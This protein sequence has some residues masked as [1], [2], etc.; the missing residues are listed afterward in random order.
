MLKLLRKKTL[1]DA[2]TV[3]G[4]PLTQRSVMRHHM[5]VLSRGSGL[6]AS[7]QGSAWSPQHPLKG[8]PIG[9]A[10]EQLILHWLRAS[11]DRRTKEQTKL[12]HPHPTTPMSHWV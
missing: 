2:A 7:K 6:G 10:E 11:G 8:C 3:R 1:L 5:Q 12:S 4:L 9:S